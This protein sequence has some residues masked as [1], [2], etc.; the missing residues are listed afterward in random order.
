M[1]INRQLKNRRRIFVGV[2]G[3]SEKSFVVW[4]QNLCD[5]AEMRVHLDIWVAGGGD[6]KKLF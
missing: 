3:K 6:T 1:V 2:E 5:E 4:I